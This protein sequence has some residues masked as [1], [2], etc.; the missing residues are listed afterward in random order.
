MLVKEW[1]HNGFA[2]VSFVSEVEALHGIIDINGRAFKDKKLAVQLVNPPK[3]IG[4][5]PSP[6]QPIQT[7]PPTTTA[8]PWK[9]SSQIMASPVWTVITN[10][11]K[12]IILSKNVV[13]QI[14]D[15]LKHCIVAT[16]PSRTVVSFDVQAWPE[17]WGCLGH[18]LVSLINSLHALLSF[19]VEEEATR[20][21]AE[22]SV[23]QGGPFS[24][25]IFW[26]EDSDF[27]S[28]WVR[29]TGIPLRA[30]FPESIRATG[31]F[32]RKVV[33]VDCPTTSDSHFVYE[34]FWVSWLPS[35]VELKSIPLKVEDV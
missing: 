9:P 22:M 14:T 29:V 30:W 10:K 19:E 7:V 2:F 16:F 24:N 4:K 32:L 20:L 3:V 21:L 12:S 8:T 33:E 23:L 1:N 6:I 28:S 35:I 5:L 26:S 31:D 13:N 17:H 34:R 27:K 11:G 25:P 15:S 18:V